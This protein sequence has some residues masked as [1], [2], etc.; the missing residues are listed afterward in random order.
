MINEVSFLFFVVDAVVVFVVV[1][2][3]IY[4]LLKFETNIANIQVWLG[5]GGSEGVQR[6]SM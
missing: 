6:L 5:G 2:G 3:P 4:L 1:V